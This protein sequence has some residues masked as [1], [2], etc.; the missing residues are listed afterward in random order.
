[1]VSLL[2][3]VSLVGCCVSE[4]VDQAWMHIFAKNSVLPDCDSQTQAHR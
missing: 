3:A 4:S 1:M 2:I